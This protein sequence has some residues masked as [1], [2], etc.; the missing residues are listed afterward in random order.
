MPPAIEHY[1]FGT[2]TVDGTTYRSD[3]VILPGRVVPDWWRRQG[4]SLALDDL[5]DVVAD[6]PNTLVVGTGAYGAMVVPERTVAALEALGIEITAQPT[7]EAVETYNRLAP[8]GRV[9]AAL[10]LTC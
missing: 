10:H 2:I 3:V 8:A 5:T 6:P 4:H 9:A 7:A 1:A